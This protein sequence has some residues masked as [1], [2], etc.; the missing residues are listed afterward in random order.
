MMIIGQVTKKDV[1]IDDR[2]NNSHIGKWVIVAD[3]DICAFANNK[4]EAESKAVEIFYGGL[5]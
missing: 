1:C 2:F 4:Q 3:G 5:Y